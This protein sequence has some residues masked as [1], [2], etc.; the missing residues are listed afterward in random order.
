M[1]FELE[2]SYQIL[3]NTPEVLISLLGNIPEEWTMNNEGKD[4]WSPYDI[5]GHL[6]H[7]EKTDWLT[8]TK[9]IL[10]NK[11]GRTFDSF[12]RFAQIKDSIGK[13][14]E[15][16]LEEFKLL[17]ANNIKELKA[18]NISPEQYSLEAEHLELG[19][20]NLKQLLSTWLVHDL[21]HINQITRVMAKQ[22]KNEVGPWNA[23]IGVLNR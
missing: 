11:G 12:D 10:S 14:L 22:Y 6:V 9:I 1:E 23:Y 17:R 19:T 15:D 20:V 16:L 4:T 21:G 5:M 2:K 18:M 7:G 13:S 8:R 3:E